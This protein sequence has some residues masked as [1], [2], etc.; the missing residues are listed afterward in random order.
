VS[1]ILLLAVCLALAGCGATMPKS[2]N[3]PVPVYCKVEIPVEPVWIQLPDE[4]EVFAAV[5]ALLA[6]RRQRI[7]YTNLLLAA[8]RGCQPPSASE[9][10]DDPF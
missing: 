2:A 7:A 5:R 8:L 4:D 1:R 9:G 10:A 6:E 3:I